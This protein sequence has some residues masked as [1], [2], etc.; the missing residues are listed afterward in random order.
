MIIR[1]G[2]V[3]VLVLMLL[4]WAGNAYPAREIVIGEVSSLSGRF[5]K[6]GESVHQGVELAIDEANKAGGIGGRMIRLV[7]RDD[8]GNP[9]KAIE[10]AESLCLKD[11]AVALTGGYVDSLVGPVAEVAEK[12]RVPYVAA[13]SLLTKLTG[14]GLQY[15]FRISNIHGYVE[16]MAEVISSLGAER[17]AIIHSVTPGA[18]ELS[19]LLSEELSSRGMSVIAVEKFKPG[20]SDFTPLLLKVFKEKP[21]VLVSLGFLQDNLLMV[22]QM[23]ENNLYPGAFMGAF[24]MENRSL[25]EDLGTDSDYLMGTTAWEDSVPL[26]GTGEV[27]EKYVNSFKE[28]FGMVPEPLTMHGYTAARVIIEALRKLEDRG[29]MVTRDDLRDAIRKTDLLLPME[30]VTFDER[31]EP[32]SYQ[33]FVFQILDGRRHLLHPEEL[34]QIKAKYPAPPWDQR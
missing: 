29:G 3:A 22:K 20:T 32:R 14:M 8:G 27:S 1:K 17:A 33:R 2:A 21:E 26:P 5:A 13:A 7:T 28:K 11:K 18:T 34:R 15:F 30:R 12:N 10:A 16:P 6:P 25:I 24:G 23:K 31:G 9:Q 19:A 4:L